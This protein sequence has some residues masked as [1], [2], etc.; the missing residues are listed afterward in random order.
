[1][2]D[3][4]AVAARAERA[5]RNLAELASCPLTIEDRVSRAWA[6]ATYAG[7]RQ[8]FTVTM[9]ATHYAEDWL[10]EIPMLEMNIQGQL[11]A[12]AVVSGLTSTGGK[13]RATIELLLVKL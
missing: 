2:S 7:S 8:T 12:D 10:A 1:M 3:I 5:L 13:I 4:V 9:Q 6:S 11:L